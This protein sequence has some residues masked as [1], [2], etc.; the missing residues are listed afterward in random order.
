MLVG[1]PV[2]SAFF[3]HLYA[4]VRHTGG[5]HWFRGGELRA[6]AAAR[7]RF[8]T[9]LAHELRTP[10][11]I[12]KSN[13]EILSGRRGGGD[14]K[15]ALAVMGATTERMAK[16]VD[17]FLAAA[18]LDFPETELDKEEFALADLFAEVCDDCAALAEDK[19]VE[20]VSECGGTAPLLADREK[21]REVMLN[22][23][24]NALKHTGRGGEI[25]LSGRVV[26]NG[27]ERSAEIAVADTGSGIARAEL[28]RIF[29]RFYRMS[30][31]AAKGTG[32][33]LHICQKIAAAHGGRLMAESDLG[34]GSRFTLFV[35]L[36]PARAAAA[37][38]ERGAAAP[39]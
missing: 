9:D 16:M 34:K 22:L 36:G 4:L 23:I 5:L 8:F 35:P 33:G 38:P 29:E 32:I 27:D 18:R 28:P 11:A 12:I 10:I 25:R 6:V 3:S 39:E 37:L 13:L 15:A 17:G 30:G 7:D 1:M 24:S 19:G 14:R 31:D 20:L 26:A 21:I 2:F